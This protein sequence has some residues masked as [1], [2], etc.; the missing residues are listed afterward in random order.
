ML[1]NTLAWRKHN[2]VAKALDA[3]LP[4]AERCR[5]NVRV[6][7]SVCVLQ[8]SALCVLPLRRFAAC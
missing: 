8:F 2:N 5:G 3:N 1:E 7:G 4:G 6:A